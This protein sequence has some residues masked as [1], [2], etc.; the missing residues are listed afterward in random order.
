[1]AFAAFVAFELTLI[2]VDEIPM[3]YSGVW[4]FY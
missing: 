4:D 1:M 3:F 2:A